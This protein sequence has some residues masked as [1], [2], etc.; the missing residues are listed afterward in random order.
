MAVAKE[1]QKQRPKEAVGYLFEG[2]AHASQKAWVEAVSAYRAG[3]KEV[4][5]NRRPGDQAAYGAARRW[6]H[7]EA[8]KFAETWLKEHAKDA[9]FRLY[10][11]EMAAARKD[12][13]GA[14]KQYRILLEAQPDNPAVLN[15]LAWVAGQLKD[16]KAIEYAEKANRLAPNQPALMDTLGSADG[17]GRYCSRPRIAQEGRGDW[18][19]RR[20]R[21]VSI[22]PGR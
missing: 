2:D 3:L 10:L 11:A 17:Q 16:P 9:R 15:N 4:G 14:V 6:Q 7:A 13:A 19:R 22:T 18:R 20:R 12:Y 1:V 5:G 21:F 8:D